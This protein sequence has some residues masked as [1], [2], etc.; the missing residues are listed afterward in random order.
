MVKRRMNDGA[1]QSGD[2][3]NRLL[4][5]AGLGLGIGCLGMIMFIVFGFLALLAWGV[6]EG[7]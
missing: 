3:Q 7:R 5:Q 1:D 4:A 2:E 6:V